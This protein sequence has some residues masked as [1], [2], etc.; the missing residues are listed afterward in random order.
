[1]LSYNSHTAYIQRFKLFTQLFERLIFVLVEEEVFLTW[2]V[3]P[4]VFDAFIHFAFIFHFL[5]VFDNFERSTRTHGVV[6]KFFSGCWPGRI[7]KL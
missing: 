3:R 2:I 1:M 5:K 4:D 7:F 6:D